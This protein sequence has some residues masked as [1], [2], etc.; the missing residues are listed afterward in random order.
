MECNCFCCFKWYKC[1][2]ECFVIHPKRKRK[3]KIKKVDFDIVETK[4]YI[5]YFPKEP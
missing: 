3:S 5:I 1:I 4:S 2:I